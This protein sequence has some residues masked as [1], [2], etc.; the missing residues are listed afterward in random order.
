MAAQG[1]TAQ[2][3]EVEKKGREE[4]NNSRGYCC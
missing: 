4:M 2:E 3:A 1:G